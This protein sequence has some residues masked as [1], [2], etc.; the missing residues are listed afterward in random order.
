[1]SPS[2]VSS[3]TDILAA[4]EGGGAFVAKVARR[5]EKLRSG[6]QRQSCGPTS[7]EEALINITTLLTCTL[8][9]CRSWSELT[10]ET[11]LLQ[12]IFWYN[13][14]HYTTTVAVV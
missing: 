2:D 3:S 4:I 6:H 11:R 10:L 8:L 1:M 12:R 14:I 7:H 13:L 5:T 9:H